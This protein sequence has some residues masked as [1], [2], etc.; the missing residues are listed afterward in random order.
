MII[1]TRC[2]AYGDGWIELNAQCDAQTPSRTQHVNKCRTCGL[3]IESRIWRH[4]LDSL[5]SNTLIRTN[6]WFSILFF[7]FEQNRLVVFSFKR[8][9]NGVKKANRE[10]KKMFAFI[11]FSL[12]CRC[13][14]RVARI[15]ERT[16]YSIETNKMFNSPLRVNEQTKKKSAREWK[17]MRQQDAHTTRWH[18]ND[19]NHMFAG[20]IAIIWS[21]GCTTSRRTCSRISLQ[22]NAYIVYATIN[23]CV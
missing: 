18:I 20:V 9:L 19:N 23:K 10:R 21:W 5:T 22:S 3:F 15:V 4:T 1:I 7:R 11:F 6:F 16:D 8:R 14:G 17:T 2:M 12:R 13:I